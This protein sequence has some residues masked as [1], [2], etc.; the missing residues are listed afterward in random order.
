LLLTKLE[1]HTMVSVYI[2]NGDFENDEKQDYKR[3]EKFIA[4][5]KHLDF[6]QVKN[7]KDEVRKEFIIFHL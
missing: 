4:T 6:F 3:D 5:I 7:T 1:Y 2:T